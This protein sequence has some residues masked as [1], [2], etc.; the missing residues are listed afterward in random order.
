MDAPQTHHGIELLEQPLSVVRCFLFSPVPLG[1]AVQERETRSDGDRWQ[2]SKVASEDDGDATKSDVRTF[3]DA[4]ST[5]LLP[6]TA[7]DLVDQDAADHGDLVDDQE[8]HVFEVRFQRIEV[9][10]FERDQLT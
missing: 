2:L 6:Q 10:A 4:A 1:V 8:L 5:A 7:M 3:A 9:L